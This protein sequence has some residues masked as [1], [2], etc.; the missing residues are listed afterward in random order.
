MSRPVDPGSAPDTPFGKRLV[1]K[2]EKLVKLQERV[3][4]ILTDLEKTPASKKQISEQ[5]ITRD[6]YGSGK[7]FTSADD[8]ANLYEKVHAD[9]DTLWKTFNDQIEAFGLMA[10][11]VDKSFNG[12]DAEQARRMQ[13]I[14]ERTREH[15]RDPEAV[16][17]GDHGDD[18]GKHG[19]EQ[20]DGDPT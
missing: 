10:L 18:G 16:K 9:L 17:K 8:L 14:A 13:E 3:E 15:Y 5:S 12:L 19:S 11:V 7:E 2:A 6:A 4:R 1:K 20:V